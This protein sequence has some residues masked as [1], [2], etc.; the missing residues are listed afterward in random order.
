M[1]I[2]E[3]WGPAMRSEKEDYKCMKK[4]F[5]N[6]TEWLRNGKEEQGSGHSFAR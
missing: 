2:I 5:R 4:P 1:R 3:K 6:P